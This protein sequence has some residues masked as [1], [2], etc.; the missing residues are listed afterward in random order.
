VRSPGSPRWCSLEEIHRVPEV[1][2]A[3]TL[4][5]YEDFDIR[6]EARRGDGCA[7]HAVSAVAGRARGALKVADFAADLEAYRAQVE[8]EPPE[9]APDGAGAP[10]PR[11]MGARRADSRELDETARILGRALFAGLFRGDVLDLYRESLHSLADDSD[12]GL[13]VRLI[14]DP[15]RPGQLALCAVP[16]ELLREAP[17]DHPLALDRHRGVVRHLELTTPVRRP[18]LEPP[19]RTLVLAANPSDASDLDLRSEVQQ[20]EAAWAGRGEVRVIYEPTLA[21]VRDALV[22]ERYHQV[23]FAGHGVFERVR[24]EGAI[25]LCH[26]D[27]CLD[28]VGSRELVAVLRDHTTLRL[29]VV[30]ACL[31]GRVSSEATG[32]PLAGVAIALALADV[33]CVVAHQLRLDDPA[34]VVFGGVLHRRLA[35]GD[36]VEAAVV[37]AR[38]AVFERSRRSPEWAIPA[39]F[40]QQALDEAPSWRHDRPRVRRALEALDGE[41]F[42][43]VLSDFDRQGSLRPAASP[44]HRELPAERRRQAEKLLSLAEERGEG[45]WLHLQ[46]SILGVRSP[47]SPFDHSLRDWVCRPPGGWQVTGGTLAG[48]GFGGTPFHDPPDVLQEAA[49]LTWKGLRFRDGELRAWLW[50]PLL[51]QE[52]GAGLV[53]QHHETSRSL[54]LGLLRSSPEEGPR[55]EIWRRA[56]LGWQRLAVQKLPD[57]GGD[58]GWHRLELRVRGSDVELRSSS[59]VSLKAT[60]AAEL[61]GG[62]TGLVRLGSTAVQVQELLLSVWSRRPPRSNRESSQREQRRKVR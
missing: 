1:G 49:L 46:E 62:R 20:I 11:E 57:P 38:H 37:E 23:H 48:V 28:R 59:G 41:R 21:K 31:S 16:W 25:L 8:P 7:I 33:P 60:S 53:L 29:V 9:T 52:A 10:I 32:G 42:A 54:L 17:S 35:A 4:M 45:A 19:V 61:P 5:D 3:S 50:I 24:G 34:A 27:G 15:S 51:P 55:A 30:N 22:S 2:P 14:F 36:P 13:R 39:L 58:R 12:R 6:F 40:V 44:P 26:A 47:F 56:G 18:S 43:T